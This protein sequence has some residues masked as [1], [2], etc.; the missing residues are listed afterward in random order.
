[1]SHVLIIDDEQSICWGLSRL[2]ESLGHTVSVAA[3]AEQGFAAA[4]GRPPDA[5]VLDFR[6]PGLDGL[7]AM[8]RFHQ[9]RSEVPV[10]IMT[11][12]GDLAT[13]VEAVRHGAFDYLVKPFE[14][15]VAQRAIERAIAAPAA[16]SAESGAARAGGQPRIVGSS[17]A[18]Q[19]VFKRIAVVAPTEACVHIRGESGTG[20]EL[21]ARAI[22][23]YS[24]RAGG[25]F[26]PVNIASL[27][28]SLA[29]SELFGHVRGA[30][31]GADQHHQGL[32]EHACGG[33]LFFDEV[34]D[35]P[36]SIQVK[37]L[38]VLE[39]GDILPVGADRAVRGDFRVVSATHQDLHQRVVAGE[40]REDLYFRLITFEIEVPPLR[41]R[42][43]D[44]A[45]LAEHFWRR[46]RPRTAGAAA[47][48]GRNPAV[49]GKPRVARQ[50]PGVAERPGARHDSGAGRAD[51]ARAPASPD[52]AGRRFRPAA[53]SH[54]G[55]DDPRL[56]RPRASRAG[57]GARSLRADVAD[58][59]AAPAPGRLA[60]QRRPVPR[61]GPGA[62]APSRD[63]PAQSRLVQ[64][65]R[66]PVP[67]MV[68]TWQMTVW[69]VH[70]SAATTCV[71]AEAR[72]IILG[73]RA[74][75]LQEPAMSLGNSLAV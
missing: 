72:R 10:I 61:G 14:L 65:P 42:Q 30:F 12:Y 46:W 25:P 66:G 3:S 35:I 75:T 70:F 41:E 2:V 7:S 33:T 28:P 55:F 62:R 32:L 69:Q 44:I 51:L 37:L 38:R 47:A 16:R 39:Y 24:R 73:N 29:E 56:G 1:M 50:H 26:V 5:I 59:R 27:S 9:E 68:G 54:A 11:A 22:H 52:A 17:P 63:A 74:F 15:S 53:G 49:A 40:F 18:I 48:G 31:T 23:R 60:A 57:G 71:S 19:E 4:A 45:A 34:A 6:L 36:M 64:G 67:I 21:V 20:K 8:R 43:S 58:R 13:A